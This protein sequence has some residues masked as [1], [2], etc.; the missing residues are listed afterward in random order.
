MGGGEIVLY[1]Y[2]FAFVFLCDEFR[3]VQQHAKRTYIDM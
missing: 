2:V 1:A 3:K